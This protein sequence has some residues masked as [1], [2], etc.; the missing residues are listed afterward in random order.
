MLKRNRPANK[1]KSFPGP[2]THASVSNRVDD[3]ALFTVHFQRML[4]GRRPGVTVGTRTRI[5]VYFACFGVVVSRPPTA[6]IVRHSYLRTLLLS[7]FAP[8]SPLQAEVRVHLS[9][10][11]AFPGTI[12]STDRREMR[13][14]PS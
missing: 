2:P 9:E 13:G 14:L 3:E 11:T 10:A 7:R 8:S 1:K 12:H 5:H 6:I 4:G